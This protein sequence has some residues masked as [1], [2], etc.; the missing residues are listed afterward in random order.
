MADMREAQLIF[1]RHPPVALAWQARCYGQSDPGLSR[2]GTRM[3]T[4][5]VRQLADH[6]P[7]HIIHSGMRRAAVVADRLGKA[8]C[9]TPVIECDWRERHFGDWEGQSWNA[10]YRATGNAMDGM[11]SAPDS[12]RPGGSGETTSQLISRVKRGLSLCPE[13]GHTVIISHGGPIAVAR[14]IIE[15]GCVADLPKLIIPTATLWTFGNIEKRNA[16]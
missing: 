11:L 16:H 7:D 12:F 4:C 13:K 1:V 5:L 14:M 2:E 3:V 9:L 8:L 6:R 15:G 10:V